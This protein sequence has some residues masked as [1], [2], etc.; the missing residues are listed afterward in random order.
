M[1]VIS[2]LDL[3]LKADALD[4]APALLRETLAATRAFEGS[5]GVD[6]ALDADDPTHYLLVEKWESLAHDD[7]YRACRATPEGQH[8]LGSLAAA[9]PVLTR[10]VIADDI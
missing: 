8:E 5:L 4:A 10:A 3:H 6:V 1:A 9:A 2:I 7:A